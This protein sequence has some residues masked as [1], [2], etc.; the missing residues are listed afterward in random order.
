MLVR[1]LGDVHRDH[2][3]LVR[4]ELEQ[5]RRLSNEIS[6][7]RAQSEPARALDNA[8]AKTNGARSTLQSAPAPDEPEEAP[9]NSDPAT[10]HDLVTE[11]LSA[12]SGSARAAGGKCSSCSCDLELARW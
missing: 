8:D 9:P 2:L 12:W 10:V 1:L 6:A 5:I 3:E 4:S 11:R 7:T